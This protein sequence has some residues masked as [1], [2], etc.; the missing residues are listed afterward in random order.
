MPS[1]SYIS[2]LPS[3]EPLC[4]ITLKRLLMPCVS[5]PPS[6]ER[7]CLVTNP[8][9]S[10]R[11]NMESAPPRT[12]PRNRSSSTNGAITT[13][14]TSG[15]SNTSEYGSLRIHFRTTTSAR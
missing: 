4:Y 11:T 3:A 14:L 5:M 8:K 13:T 6:T 2:R 1:S 7:L 9:I 12:A 10:P 15:Q